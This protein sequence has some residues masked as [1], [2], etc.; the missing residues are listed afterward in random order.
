MF[1]FHLAALQSEL[2]PY[3]MR[4]STLIALALT[5]ALAVSPRYCEGARLRG[6]SLTEEEEDF[7]PER[8][9]REYGLLRNRPARFDNSFDDYGHLRFGRSYE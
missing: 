1:S 5:V 7:H 8:T 2:I 3:N 4:F 9:Y 6:L